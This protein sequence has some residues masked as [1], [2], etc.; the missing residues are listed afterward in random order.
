M[1]AEKLRELRLERGITAIFV[2]KKLHIAQST[3]SSYEHG[4]RKPPYVMLLA[5]AQLYNVP[6]SVLYDD[7]N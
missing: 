4:E 1:L 5:L 2:A 3:L 6:I 7:K